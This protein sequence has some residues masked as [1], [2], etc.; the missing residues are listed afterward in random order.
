MDNLDGEISRTA[1]PSSTEP[2]KTR[3]EAQRDQLQQL[4][5]PTS[6]HVHLSPMTSPR[7]STGNVYSKKTAFANILP[8]NIYPRKRRR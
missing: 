7:R 4:P 2:V 8:S 1:E 6:N 5:E 3:D